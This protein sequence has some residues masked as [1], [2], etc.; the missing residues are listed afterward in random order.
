MGERRLLD[1]CFLTDKERLRHDD[2][3]GIL[4][5]RARPVAGAE[6]VPLG[7]AVGRIA[8]ESVTSPFKV[9][10]SDN[11]AV[12][13]YAFAHADYEAAG[14]YFPVVERIAAGHPSLRPHM[15]GTAVRIFTGGLMPAG[16]DTVAMQEDCETHEVNGH[17]FVAIPPE[18]KRGANR[19]KAGEDLMEG[20]VIVK[21]GSRL[22]P[23]EIAALASVGVERVKVFCRLRVALVSTGDE[24]IRPG[25]SLGRG[26][27]YDSNFFLLSGLLKT[28]DCDAA[29]IGVLPDDPGMVRKR[30]LDLAENHHAVLT[31]VG[32][33]RGEEDHL[34]RSLREMG[35][36]H[37]WQ[38]AVKP[39][40]P[41]A[42]GQIGD[43]PVLA[44]PGNPVAAFVCFLLYVRPLLVT[45]SGGAWL[46]PERFLLPAAFEI[47]ARKP[48][49]REFW[50]GRLASDDAK[51]PK[52]E[53]FP[54]DG[55]GLITSL[56]ES[57]GLIE[58]EEDLPSVRP[59]DLVPFLPFSGF[60]LPV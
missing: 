15:T 51:R 2:A 33:S 44:L 11:A 24:L 49:R 27:V 57:D 19:R 50:R 41:M 52:V 13:G 46:E 47:P 10:A 8:A 60:G 7:Q 56:R 54:R 6:H 16:A 38:L 26:Q 23:Q 55:S 31:T 53:K 36:R 12:D 43:C 18:L 20:A 39:G 28:I 3:I 48:G 14:G 5:S 4:R 9:P 17:A 30:L 37:I 45:L 1:D 21:T 22:R 25:A 32:A 34:A 40:R 59:G 58:I 29:D 35:K 42:F